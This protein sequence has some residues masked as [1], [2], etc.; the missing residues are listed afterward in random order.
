MNIDKAKFLK[1]CRMSYQFLH[2][3]LKEVDAGV[4]RAGDPSAEFF[5]EDNRIVVK[6]DRDTF[7]VELPEGIDVG[8]IDS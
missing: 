2:E 5:V 7:T 4:E 1:L 6:V 8:E 3:W